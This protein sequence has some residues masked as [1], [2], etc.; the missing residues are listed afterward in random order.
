MLD[1]LGLHPGDSVRLGNASFTVRGALISEPDRVAAPL[2]LGPRV[3]IAADALAFDR[4]D[5]PRLHGAVR[6]PRHSAG[7]R[8]RRR[9]ARRHCGKPSRA[10]AG[11]SAIRATPRPA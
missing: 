3:L 10:R 8:H 4:A 7:S 6:H 5:R 1:R 2:I 9:L 11:A